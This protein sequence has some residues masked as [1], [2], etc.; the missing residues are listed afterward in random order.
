MTNTLQKTT[1]QQNPATVRD[2]LESKAF[3]EQIA[4]VLPKHMTPER[5]VRVAITTMTRTPK[6]LECTQASLFNCLLSLSQFGLEPDG[7]R[8]HL[9]PYKN[10]KSGKYECQLIVDYKGLAEL[11]YRSGIVSTLHADVVRDGDIFVYNKGTL[12]SHVPWFLRRDLRPDQPGEVY[13][14]YALVTMK[15]GTE[16][17]EVVSLDDVYSIRDNSQGWRAFKA[18]FA[19]QC[20]WDPKNPVSEQEMMKKTAFRRLSKWLPLSPEIRDGIEAEDETTIDIPTKIVNEKPLFSGVTES[21]LIEPEG[22]QT[23]EAEPGQETQTLPT[24]EVNKPKE[25]TNINFVKGLR[26]LLDLHK[27]TEAEFLDFMRV[28]ASWD[29]SLASLEEV[30]TVAPVKLEHAYNNWENIFAR[31]DEIKKGLLK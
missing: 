24:K 19:S 22:Q 4:R 3:Q 20:P 13:A 11:V 21:K 15:D 25:T 12:T 5:F 27:K 8:A 10:A 2:H 18:G 30:S 29:D 26:G 23:E 31:M 9:I 16:K 1:T 17:V 14:V 7:R 28:T 6:L